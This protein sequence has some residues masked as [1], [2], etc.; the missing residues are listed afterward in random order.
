MAEEFDLPLKGVLSWLVWRGGSHWGASMKSQG[1]GPGQIILGLALKAAQEPGLLDH[2]SPHLTP[3]DFVSNR[4]AL[5]AILDPQ[6]VVFV[7]ALTFDYALTKLKSSLYQEKPQVTWPLDAGCPLE[8]RKEARQIA[9]LVHAH[10]L[11]MFPE[12]SQNPLALPHSP[13]SEI[14]LEEG[15]LAG[16]DIVG[17]NQFFQID[18]PRILATWMWFGDMS[19]FPLLAEGLHL[20]M[21]PTPYYLSEDETLFFRD[22][23]KPTSKEIM[24][25][26]L[27]LNCW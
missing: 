10:F 7:K 2:Y 12:I 18:I 14:L 3:E 27:Y 19:D 22:E 4:L 17:F 11:I 13:I 24:A 26:G 1:Y 20:E 23:E 9:L 6:K 5:R 16:F 8:D 21:I 15:G 25:N